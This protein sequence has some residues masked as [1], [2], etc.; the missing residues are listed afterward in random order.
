MLFPA[1]TTLVVID[2]QAAFELCFD[3]EAIQT[4]ENG[5][6]KLVDVAENIGIP[7]ITSLIETN[8]INAKLSENWSQNSHLRQGLVGQGLIFGMIWH[9]PKPCSLLIDLA[10]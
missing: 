6:A 2:H 1:R 9:F 10:C 8:Q 4:V 5:I 3:N 7:I